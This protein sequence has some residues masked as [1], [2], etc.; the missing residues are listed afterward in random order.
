MNIALDTDR[1]SLVH[2]DTLETLRAFTDKSFDIVVTDPPYSPHTHAKLG[3]ERCA[4]GRQ[5]D[6]AALTFPPVDDAMIAELAA[7]FVRLAK[8]W[9]IIFSDFR[10]SGTWGKAVEAAGGMW[11]RTGAWVKTSPMPQMTGDRPAVGHE[12]IVIGY[13]ALK[14][15][16][17][18]AHGRPC[19]WRGAR[20]ADSEHPNQKPVWLLQS[21]LGM[22]C[23][24][25]GLCLDAFAGSFTTA[26]AALRPEHMPGESPLETTCDK[27]RKK[28]L[29]QYAAPLPQGVR[30]VGI[31]GDPEYIDLAIRRIREASPNV[32][33]A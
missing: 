7:H 5:V 2:G 16:S 10:Q 23:P 9:I 25:G 26:V 14:N 17:W 28:I 24:P 20:D 13:A 18:N 29:E 21:L 22:F 3:K 33:A 15:L 8:G 6:R 27:C 4:D 12:D 31:E 32:V 1:V 11:V 30:V 19:T